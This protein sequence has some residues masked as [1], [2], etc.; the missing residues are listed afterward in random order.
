MSVN[1]NYADLDFDDVVVDDDV[2][3][4]QQ[5]RAAGMGGGGDRDLFW[6]PDCGRQIVRIVPFQRLVNG[7]ARWDFHM[8]VHF[9]PQMKRSSFFREDDNPLG[10]LK[11][12]GLPGAV[13]QCPSGNWGE[14]CPV[15]ELKWELWKWYKENTSQAG[16]HPD[17]VSN[18]LY[19]DFSARVFVLVRQHAGEFLDSEEGRRW[20]A[21][22][23]K[24]LKRNRKAFE[25]FSKAIGETEQRYSEHVERVQTEG[26]RVQLAI[27]YKDLHKEVLEVAANR[28]AYGKVYHPIDGRDFVVTTTVNPDTGYRDHRINV[29]DSVPMVSTEDGEPDEGR[30][31]ELLA[32]TFDIGRYIAPWDAALR[33]AVERRVTELRDSL[34]PNADK[35]AKPSPKE[36]DDLGDY[37]SDVDDADIDAVLE[38]E[39][40]PS[41]EKNA[42][43]TED[44]SKAE[45]K[46]KSPTPS[47]PVAESKP[48]PKVETRK[49]SVTVVEEKKEEEEEQE[50]SP[51]KP[52]SQPKLVSGV[53]ST[54][55]K[56]GDGAKKSAEDVP[57]Q[58]D[59]A[60]TRPKTQITDKGE[61]TEPTTR[62]VKVN[63]KEV[64]ACFQ[65]GLHVEGNKIC[66]MCVHEY[67][68]VV[69]DDSDDES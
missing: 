60:Q 33:R 47:R 15:C 1:E 32:Q 64:P 44:R 6:S 50:E 3:D 37:S 65:K 56:R 25:A 30:I 39:S 4:E 12:D 68:C 29:L 38:E 49:V 21:V 7:V 54:T 27:L 5:R 8:P 59:A 11:A 36:L 22:E 57:E 23:G 20:R 16:K 34:G 18:G 17:M 14:K 45:S 67:D 41:P 69:N 13:L 48:A 42:P 26:D 10:R 19:G 31:R 43:K 61:P 2:F 62:K 52:V 40:K 66:D 58:P 24:K 9:H 53:K 35:T 63:G 55:P 51:P 46:T 28:S